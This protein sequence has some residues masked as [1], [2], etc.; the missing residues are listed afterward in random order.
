MGTRSGSVKNYESS[1]FTSGFNTKFCFKNT[2]TFSIQNHVTDIL[3]DIFMVKLLKSGHLL[4]WHGPTLPLPDRPPRALWIDDPRRDDDASTSTNQWR[5]S[6]ASEW[7]SR[8]FFGANLFFLV[9][10]LGITWFVK[11]SSECVFNVDAL[12]ICWGHCKNQTTS[13]FLFFWGVAAFSTK[14]IA[15]KSLVLPSLGFCGRT[16]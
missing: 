7:S 8:G 2:T 4:Q 9:S 5:S 1:S 13:A 6:A 10:G 12:Q 14:D 16:A 11:W 15:S 3:S